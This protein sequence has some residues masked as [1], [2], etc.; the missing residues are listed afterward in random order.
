MSQ[1]VKANP[2]PQRRQTRLARHH[3]DSVRRKPFRASDYFSGL[4][5]LGFIALLT[6]VLALR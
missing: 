5:V 6:L 1:P 3:F 4:I 2:G